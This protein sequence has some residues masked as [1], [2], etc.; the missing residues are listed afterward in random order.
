VEIFLPSHNVQPLFG[1]QAG[2]IYDGAVDP[3]KPSTRHLRDAREWKKLAPEGGSR[4]AVTEGH[5]AHVA[6]VH[7]VAADGHQPQ[8]P[9]D[10]RRL[11]A[12]HSASGPETASAGAKTERGSRGGW[13]LAKKGRGAPSGRA[14]EPNTIMAARREYYT[15]KQVVW[16]AR[17]LEADGDYR[18]AVKALDE[19]VLKGRGLRSGELGRLHYLRSGLLSLEGAWAGH[20]LGV[21]AP[22]EAEACRRTVRPSRAYSA[23]IVL[24]D[25]AT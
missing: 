6:H 2:D 8:P 23:P 3:K 11:D 13:G 16:R 5:V 20:A 7:G 14:P 10:A 15:Y 9:A 17:L 18:G 24:W 4:E 21:L 19:G 22:A 25:T 12:F 1:F